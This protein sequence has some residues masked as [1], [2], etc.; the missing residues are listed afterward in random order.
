MIYY[1]NNELSKCGNDNIG[2]KTTD[3]SMLD[4]T[5]FKELKA[6]DEVV[7]YGGDGTINKF[8]NNCYTYP[9]LTIVPRGTGND[10]A[11]SLTTEY[12]AVQVFAANGYKYVNGFDIGFGALVCK[13]VEQDKKKGKLSYLLNVY[14]GLKDTKML[15]IT[16]EIDGRQIEMPN[17]FLVTAQNTKYFGG[18]MK[19][20]PRANIEADTVEVCVIGNASKYLILSIFPT[21]FLGLHMKIHKYVRVYQAREVKFELE[22]AYIAECDGEVQAEKHQFNIKKHGEIK[23]RLQS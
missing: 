13:L 8:I 12:K 18:G 14:K 1:V 17:T 16:A 11:R 9:K 19:I 5:F 6:D 23:V 22:T 20:T 3:V 4:D 10:L 21:V 7:I 2:Q 15:N